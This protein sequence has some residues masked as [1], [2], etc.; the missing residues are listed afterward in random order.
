MRA[1]GA[2]ALLVGAR[3]LVEAVAFAALAALAHAGSQGSGPMPVTPTVL[4]LLGGA[5]LL[6]TLLRELGSERR[7]ATIL[8]VTLAAGV[9]WGL[10]LPMR[11]PD[12]FATLSRIV[13]FGLLA[14]GYLWRV[15]SIARGATRWTDARDA[16]FFT[17]IAMTVAVLAPGPI[18]RGPFA[19][20]ALFVVAASGLALSLA[21]TTE[22]LSLTRG[23]AGELRASSAT[24]AM[25]MLG[26]L[27]IAAAALVPLAQEAVG[28][29]GSRLGPIAERVLYL[30]ILP[31][32]YLAA[33]IVDVLR[34]LLA[35]AKP[36]EMPR[37]L[38]ITPEEEA[39]LLRQAADARPFVFGA[40]E[41]LVVAI[42]AVVALVLLERMLRERR[43]DLAD[44]VTLE[45]ERADGIGFLDSLRALRPRRGPR[46][47]R[48]RDDGSPAAALRLLYWRFLELA[49]RRGAGWRGTSETPAEHAARIAASDPRW[50]DADP[51]VVAFQELRYGET[52]PDGAALARAR[53]ALRALEAAP[54]AS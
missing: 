15:V 40:I 5:L 13:L 47:R 43:I 49:E 1:S 54:R 7:S 10:T 36:P 48:P 4:V 44:G 11:D 29:L 25:V 35:K 32:A 37:G 31:F 42:A 20:L 23:S 41:L 33:F 28:A 38:Q 2:L 50:R 52:D 19:V 6:V 51:I 22:E 53:D 27:A 18:D 12:G 34:P 24:S 26:L 14:E 16:L 9:A 21:R 3:C 46:R 8:V 45:R 17:T 30:L 39:E